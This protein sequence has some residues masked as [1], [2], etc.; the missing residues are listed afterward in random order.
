MPV[1]PAFL[2]SLMTSHSFEIPN[3]TNMIYK[4]IVIDDSAIQRLTTTHLVNNHPNLELIGSFS[5]ASEA[6]TTTILD[7]AEILLLD[8][9]LSDIDAFEVLDKVAFR[10]AIIMMHASKNNA[11]ENQIHRI[12]DYLVKPISKKEFE[13]ALQ[14]V[15]A[16]IEA[17]RKFKD[18]LGSI[19]KKINQK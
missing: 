6:L 9:M 19:N 2:A 10:P 3:L 5:N 8:T 17:S 16:E 11:E 4:A 7:Q 15:M 12:T 14:R 18:V 1:C 13:S